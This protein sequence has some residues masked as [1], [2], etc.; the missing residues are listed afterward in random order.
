MTSHLAQARSAYLRSA[1][2]Q[3]V[4]WYPWGDE[5]FTRAR[6]ESRPIL[7]DIGAVW[8]HWCHVMDRESYEDPAVATLLNEEWVC[9]KVDRDERPDVDARYQRAVQAITGQGGWPL[10]AF[11]TPDGEVFFGGTY[12]PPQG[13]Q[14]RPGFATVLRE[15]ARAFRDEPDKVTQQ[16]AMIRRHLAEHALESQPGPVPQDLL[17]KSVQGMARVFDTQHGGFGGQPKFPHPTACEVLLHHW[18]DTGQSLPRKMV[19]QTLT[20]MARGGIHDQVGGG[21]HRYAVDAQWIVPHFEKMVYDNAELLRV[22]VHAA[23]SLLAGGRAGGPAGGAL[24][25]G[26]VGGTAGLYRRTIEGIVEW[27]FS[28]LADPLGGYY[29]SQDADVGLSDDGDYFTW[30]LAEV[31]AAVEGPE[32]DALTRRFDIAEQGEMRH[33]PTRNVLWVRDSHENIASAM[34]ISTE[35]VAKTLDRGI[36]RLRAARTRRPLPVVDTTLYVGWG[37]MMASAMLEAAAFLD[38]R[39]LD[40]HALRTLERLVTE[41]TDDRGGVR[42]AVGSDVAGLLEDHVHLA[43]AC[44]TAYECTGTGIWRTRAAAL[45]EHVWAHYGAEEGGLYDRRADGGLGLLPERIRP[46]VDAPT[47]SPNGVAAVV[48]ARLAEHLPEQPEWRTRLEL[49]L[50][51]FGGGLADLGLHGAS[52]LLGADWALHPRTHVVVVARDD[53]AGAALRRA[54]RVGF[55]PRKVVTFLTPDEPSSP[56]VPA[57]VRAMLDGASPRAYVCVGQECRPPVTSPEDLLEALQT[58]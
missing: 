16:A 12:F 35:E 17:S 11:L 51:A 19:D 20:A 50:A 47:P 21:F 3:P 4:R 9:I 55:R 52:L 23:E 58:S 29:A 10:T 7:L 36:A 25:N 42:H 48:A 31:E 2:H 8:C 37:A 34:G 27:V 18:A 32:R 28:T 54:A 57:A 26:D 5:P 38:R 1:A 24:A 41:T 40:L 46:I 49:L 30:T 39:D 33:D 53:R 14:G 13:T 6:Q 43:N 22:Y 44:V 56:T 45:M 15:L